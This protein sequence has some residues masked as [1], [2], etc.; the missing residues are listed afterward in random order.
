MSKVSKLTCGILAGLAVV[1][2]AVVI[3]LSVINAGLTERNGKMEEYG[4]RLESM[5]D[6][7]YFEL[8]DS[9][10]NMQSNLSKLTVSSGRTM[11]QSL[12]AEIIGQADSA[13]SDIGSLPLEGGCLMKSAEFINKTADY[14]SYLM[15]KLASG[16]S[17]TAEEKANL[18]GLAKSSK[19]LGGKLCEMAGDIGCGTLLRD[20]GENGGGIGM[21]FD[22]M[23]RA[24]FDYPKLIYDGPFS[25]ARDDSVKPRLPAMTSGEVRDK[26]AEELAP[27][28][29]ASVEYKG[30]LSNKA[31]VYNY[32]VTM[33][34]GGAIYVQAT[35]N[36]GMIALV[37]GS[38]SGSA[39]AENAM[40]AAK[41]FAA[42]LGY[43][44]E[45]VWVSK[46]TDGGTY[47]NLAPVVNGVIIYPDLV[48]AVVYDGGVRGFE[49]Y[50]YLANHKTRKFDKKYRDS[51]EAAA[52]LS[53]ELTVKNVNMALV[54]KNDDEILCF[55]FECEADGEQYFVFINADTLEETDIFKVIKG[56][57]GYTVM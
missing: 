49:A 56:T 55:E 18:K 34:G 57:E 6:K 22:E 26:V 43:D 2:L 25:D 3:R 50:N 35:V 33:M 37:S 30:R 12:L 42:A 23:N 41:E 44:V 4:V 31:D 20:L 29:A 1:L 9:I 16:G 19:T 38:G 36:G 28:G 5:Y 15:N 27:F 40:A 13:Q 53:P 47:V 39:S 51:G 11:Q 17:I 14:C 48:K 45:P 52:K 10:R 32:E 7:A 24:A 46:E 8:T 54:P 21:G